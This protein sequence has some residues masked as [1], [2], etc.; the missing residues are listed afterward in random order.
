MLASIRLHRG[1]AGHHQQCLVTAVSGSRGQ[2]PEWDGGAVRLKLPAADAQGEGDEASRLET[3]PGERSPKKRRSAVHA[4]IFEFVSAENCSAASRSRFG[5]RRQGR[6]RCGDQC[7]AIP[8]SR[9]QVNNGWARPAPPVCFSHQ[10]E[11]LS[12][13]TGWRCRPH[14]LPATA[15]AQMSGSE[16]EAQP[17][18][19]AELIRAASAGRCRSRPG[20][21]PA[22]QWAASHCASV[23]TLG[24]PR[25]RCGEEQRHPLQR[26]LIGWPGQTRGSHAR[27]TVTVKS[28]THWRA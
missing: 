8:V 20:P 25:P 18:D 14:T 27:A 4:A 11:A 23:M 12:A 3:M 5:C 19:E 10:V 6:W 16:G 28:T 17:S 7:A 2:R 9:R 24:T 13:D 21:D 1:G 15:P 26:S 22:P